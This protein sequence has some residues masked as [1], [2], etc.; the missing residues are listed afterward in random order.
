MFPTTRTFSKNRHG[1]FRENDL[2][3]ELFEKTV[4]RCI[5]EGLIRADTNKQGS[6]EASQPV[7]WDDLARSRR[8]VREYLGTLDEAA[9]GAA[10]GAR[11]KFRA[12]IRRRNGRFA[13]APTI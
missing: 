2:L 10:N 7:D 4:P 12:P 5:A 11:P 13:Y 9:W 6:A 3:N 1:R 8:S